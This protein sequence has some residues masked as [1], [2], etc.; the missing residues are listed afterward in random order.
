MRT[1]TCIVRRWFCGV[2]RLTRSSRTGSRLLEVALPSVYSISLYK[3]PQY[4]VI[5]VV[6]GVGYDD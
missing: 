1:R 5:S 6:A 4:P 2:A 3:G